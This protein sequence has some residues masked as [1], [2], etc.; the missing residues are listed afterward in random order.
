MMVTTKLKK[1]MIELKREKNIRTEF[2]F[3]IK[4]KQDGDTREITTAASVEY[5]HVVISNSRREN[6]YLC[7]SEKVS[8]Y[9]FR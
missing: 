4:N 8:A 7:T 1:A 5:F 6:K 3:H 2:F 9:F